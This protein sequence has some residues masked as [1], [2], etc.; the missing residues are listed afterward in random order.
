[1][2]QNQLTKDTL[3][4]QD[5]AEPIAVDKA[6]QLQVDATD[7][8]IITLELTLTPKL[9]LKPANQ[10]TEILV[11]KVLVTEASSNS[12]NTTLQLPITKYTYNTS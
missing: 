6:A 10:T 11:S 4:P 9:L 3:A 12:E 2:Q 5:S 1:M 8:S 7:I